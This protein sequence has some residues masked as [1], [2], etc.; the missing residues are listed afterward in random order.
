MGAY[1]CGSVCGEGPILFIVRVRVG[2]TVLCRVYD[3]STKVSQI[4]QL[5]G[6][7]VD[8]NGDQDSE[9]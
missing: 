3:S 7:C 9:D 8:I 2:I 1:V 4:T 6:L 5:V